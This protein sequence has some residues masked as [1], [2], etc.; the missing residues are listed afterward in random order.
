[1]AEIRAFGGVIPRIDPSVFLATGC[2][3]VGDVELGPGSSIWFGAVV[4]GDVNSIR[5]GARTNIQDQAVVHVT[6]GTHPTIVG[7]DVTV[8]HQAVLHGC[9]VRDR[10]L[11]G[12]G[13]IVLD[14]AVVGEEA[15]VG[16]GAL[17]PPGMVVPARA[18]VMGAPARV[19]RTLGDA[20]VD[21]LRASAAR[22]VEYAARYRSEAAAP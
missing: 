22:Y 8:G 19:R 5:I 15:I 12:I 14:G 7:D 17:V 4:R 10:C 1:M 11:I 16:A 6:G 18:L 21:G 3:V 2:V 9:T 20:D 13:A